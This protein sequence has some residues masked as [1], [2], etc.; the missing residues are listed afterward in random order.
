MIRRAKRPTKMGRF[1]RPQGPFVLAATLKVAGKMAVSV[2]VR[3]VKADW[4]QQATAGTVAHETVETHL[5]VLRTLET[6]CRNQSVLQ[7]RDIDSELLWAWL[8]SQTR[9]A[10]AVASPSTRDL[11]RSVAVTFF[12][13]CY[14][15]G[16]WDVNPADALTTVTKPRRHIA[17]LTSDDVQALKDQADC[18]RMSGKAPVDAEPGWSK[19]APALALALLG[20]QSGEV[21]AIR[22]CDIDL[23]NQVVWAHGGGDRY[24][25]RFL[26]I[27][28]DWAF[29]AIATRLA[30][31]FRP[32]GEA[33]ST[34]P[35]AYEP[36]V[37]TSG[38]ISALNLRRAAAATL[39][40]K[41]LRDADVKQPGRNRVASI[42]EYVAGRV[43][44][45]T[46]RLEA[47]AARL[48]LRSL[49]V[50]ADLV[51]VNWKVAYRIASDGVPA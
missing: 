49:D 23:I 50:A 45:E 26:L 2:A 12:R 40:D 15:L 39:I 42:N 32:H 31:L 4:Q 43:F 17:P 5:K 38:T 37:I 13:T 3:R 36:A 20:A 25:D 28:D 48:G 7:L 18:D 35:I 46:Q 19:G 33:A 27:D 14:R 41:I 24:D 11:R 1:L 8:G 10:G 21:G 51:G 22:C 47:V 29:T 9:K 34:L 44:S 30:Y 6:F 16:L